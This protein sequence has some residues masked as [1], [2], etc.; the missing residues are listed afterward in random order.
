[1]KKLK[2]MILANDTTYTYNL[3]N[4]IIERFVA[5]G[6]DVVVVSQPLLLQNELKALGC[7]LVD[8]ETNRHGTNPLSDFSLLMKFR[9]ILLDGKPDLALTYNIKPNVYAGMA[10]RMT[11]TPYFPNITGLGTAVE[12]PGLMQK[13]TIRLYKAGVAGAECVFFQNEENKKFFEDHNML[14]KGVKTRLLPGSGVS[15][16][17][18]KAMPYPADNG[19]INFLFI[20]RVMKAKGID[21]YLGAAKRIYEKHKNVVFHICGMCDDVKYT[22]L[23]QNA[24]KDGYIKYHGE[25]KD[26][27]PFFEMAHCIVH[28]SYYPEG[29]S[30]VLLEAAAHCRPIIAT[31][32]AGCRETVDDGKSGFV[33]PIKNE[34]AL[35][36]ALEKFLAM[37]W[38]QKR[39][40]GLAGRA[41][42]EKEFDRQIVV[43]AY[44]EEIERFCNKR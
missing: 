17:L 36:D 3:R 7:R 28:P 43:N 2:I 42:I 40:M 8:I 23:L 12:Y 41:K 15:L 1:M 25:Q 29:M 18:H 14:R 10:C 13:F 21:L 24:E 16:K 37:T 34:D 9:K 5:D 26:M 33:I 31:D 27:V 11:K 20:A 30:N 19:T 44:V 38:E 4:E 22:T 6:H 32:R 39:E 35:V